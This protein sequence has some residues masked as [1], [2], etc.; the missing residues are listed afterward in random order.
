MCESMIINEQHRQSKA[1]ESVEA[2]LDAADRARA[3]LKR[4]QV[5]KIKKALSKYDPFLLLPSVSDS[6]EASMR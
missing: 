3:E 4:L 6:H 2:E 5:G 1:L